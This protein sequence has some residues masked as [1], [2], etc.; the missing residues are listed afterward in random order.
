MR[1]GFPRSVNCRAFRLRPHFLQ[2]MAGEIP[3][4]R[5]TVQPNF[6]IQ[7]ES[8]FYPAGVLAAL[9]PLAG[10]VTE[11]TAIIPEVGEKESRRAAGR[12]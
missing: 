11:D 6:E 8:V 1:S 2:V 9:R 12:E 4:P 3:E 7:V 10:I 5:V